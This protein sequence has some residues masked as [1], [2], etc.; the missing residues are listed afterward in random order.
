MSVARSRPLRWALCLLVL[1]ALGCVVGADLLSPVLAY[2]LGYDPASLTGQQGTVIVAFYN[3]TP[4]PAQFRAF[5][6]LDAAD[7]TRDSRNFSAVVGAMDVANEVL[8]CPVGVV[9][10]GT[11][12]ADFSLAGADPIAAVVQAGDGTVEVSYGGQ[13]L[14]SGETYSCGDV[15][16]IRLYSAG[17]GG[18]TDAAYGVTVRVIPGW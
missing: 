10:P 13:P 18:E 3:Q 16:E 14:L 5:E 17:G 12:G 9:S 2:T 1:P 7:L 6:S 15:V 11:L 8:S 4:Y